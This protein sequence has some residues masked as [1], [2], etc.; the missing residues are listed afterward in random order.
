MISYRSKFR[1]TSSAQ[2]QNT[3]IIINERNGVLETLQTKQDPS[4]SNKNYKS[5]CEMT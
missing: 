1:K 4:K 2:K 5:L 3:F